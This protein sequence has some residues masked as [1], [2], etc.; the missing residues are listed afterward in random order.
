M[1]QKPYQRESPL[2]P[3][4]RKRLI[5]QVLHIDIYATPTKAA[6]K[7]LQLQMASYERANGVASP[8]DT[9]D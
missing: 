3:S 5:Q 9:S 7:E 8:M 6:R 4:Q 2:H 1:D